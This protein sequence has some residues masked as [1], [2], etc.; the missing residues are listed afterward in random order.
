MNKLIPKTSI[1]KIIWTF[2]DTVKLPITVR[3]CLDSWAYW[4]P[5]YKLIVL[6]KRNINDYLPGMSIL[7][8]KRVKDFPARLSDFVRIN[9]LARYGGVWTDATNLCTCSF[10]EWIDQN[11]KGFYPGECVCYYIERNTYIPRYP[12]IENWF[13][14]CRKGSKFIQALCEEFMSINNYDTVEDYID[15]VEDL[16]TELQG[17]VDFDDPAYLTMHVSIQL[18][19][20]VDKYDV[21]RLRL[22]KAEEGPF[23]Y[24]RA[25]DWK[26]KRSLT[27]L[28]KEPDLWATPF[29]KFT[30]DE[31]NFLENNKQI[32]DCIFDHAD[33]LRDEE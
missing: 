19:L 10:D 22:F 24:L 26:A 20:Q 2:W 27:K 33:D 5:D 30:G 11:I 16:G 31:R 4:N 18:I 9:V 25:G 21:S 12:V 7:K 17:I 8:L 23:R 15:Y 6:N 32:R 3:Y 28:C 1:P 29:V 14:A 13:F